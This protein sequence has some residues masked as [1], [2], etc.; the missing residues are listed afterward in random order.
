LIIWLKLIQTMRLSEFI[1]KPPNK[2]LNPDAQ[3][4]RAG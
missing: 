4:Q 3:K 1:R 2:A